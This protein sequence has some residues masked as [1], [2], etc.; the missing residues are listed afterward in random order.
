MTKLGKLTASIRYQLRGDNEYVLRLAFHRTPESQW[1]ELA[2]TILALDGLHGDIVTVKP[3]DPSSTESPFA[4]EIDY[5]QPAFI[6]WSAERMK[7][8]I[9][10]LALGVPD[11]PKKR[12]STIELG[13]PSA[14]QRA[15]AVDLPGELF[16]APARRNC[17]NARLCRV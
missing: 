3:S 6:D 2:Q 9:P 8:P 11:A 4:L 10:L 16:S 13:S 7:V 17:G 1:K 15:T 5:A 14:R 12:E